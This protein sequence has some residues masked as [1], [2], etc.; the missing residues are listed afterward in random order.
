MSDNNIVKKVITYKSG[1][2]AFSL[3]YDKN[4]LNDRLIKA[5]ILFTTVA[6]IPILPDLASRLEEELIRKSIFGTAAIEGNPLSQE[7]VN[8][9]LSQEA[10]SAKKNEAEKQ[11][12]NLKNIYNEIKKTKPLSSPCKLTEETIRE[13]HKI[14]TDG[15]SNNDNYP[16]HYRNHSVQVGNTEHGG[17]YTP[18]K[19]IEDIKTLM[20][21]FTDW[22]NSPEIMNE[23]AAI[24]AALAHYYL[25]LI[26]PFGDG[27]GRT[28]RA[29][30]AMLLTCS[31]IKFVPHMLSNFY[32]RNIDD[33][34]GAF[35]LSER[36]D[37]YD[38]TPFLEF[39]LKGVIASLEE[40]RATI[41]SFIRTFTLRDYYSYLRKK[42]EI[43]QRQFDFLTLLL[44]FAEAFS[45]K[46]L[47]EKDKFRVIYRGVSE[48]TARRDL[49]ELEGKRLIAVNDQGN[50]V[51][52]IK[53]LG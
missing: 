44:E 6:E 8:E 10:K 2:F 22:I 4:K 26:H 5:K 48:R 18:P 29:I 39:F 43:T 16:G 1:H 40:I 7:R 9:V 25:A 13:F 32:Y 36:N 49:K 12:I 3:N 46:D 42:K 38:I 51:L 30:E 33:Y 52:N 41:F 28:A 47:F 50:Y 11:I 23:D 17:V 14:I 45:L 19:I 37:T 27:N 24:R 31:G 53:A 15:S 21:A 20:S 34:F 35:S